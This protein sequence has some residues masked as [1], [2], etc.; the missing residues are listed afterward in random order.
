VL[1]PASPR[2][3]ARARGGA[4]GSGPPPSATGSEEPYPRLWV[5]GRIVGIDWQPPSSVGACAGRWQ[6]LRSSTMLKAARTHFLRWSLQPGSREAAGWS[7]GP[8]PLVLNPR[9]KA[10][11]MLSVFPW[12]A[13]GMS[14]RR[15]ASLF[16]LHDPGH[17]TQGNVRVICP[18]HGN[19]ICPRRTA[20]RSSAQAGDGCRH[21][22]RRP[23]EEAVMH[24]SRLFL[25]D[26]TAPATKGCPRL[27]AFRGAHPQLNPP[28]AALAYALTIAVP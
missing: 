12:S 16:P 10:S 18:R 19:G 11:P 6:G 21:L 27:R 14:L 22:P 24:R 3:R 4:G 2:H 1:R 20:A 26:A 8:A 7:T 28:P 15:A 9:N 23:V 5:H 17:T 25:T 13:A